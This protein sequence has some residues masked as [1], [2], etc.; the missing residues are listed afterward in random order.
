MKK[1]VLFCAQ[2]MS[3]SILVNNMKKAAEKRGF[4]CTIEAHPL[5]ADKDFGLD[6]DIIFLGPQVRFNLD[7]VKEDCP[8]VP[9]EPID[10]LAYGM[11]DGDKVIER[12]MEVLGV[13]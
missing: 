11:M 4:E 6:A 10:T 2:G 5:A 12:A 13:K 9:I 1:I 3:T 8:N 7:K